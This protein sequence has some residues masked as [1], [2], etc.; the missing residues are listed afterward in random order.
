MSRHALARCLALCLLAL[1]APVA[2]QAQPAA[3][4]NESPPALTTRGPDAAELELQRALQGRAIEGRVTIPDRS[5]GVLVQP[6]GRD[7]R[8]YRNHWITWWGGIAVLGMLAVLLIVHL[9]KGTTRIAS[10]RTGRSIRRYNLLERANHWMVAVSFIGLALTGLNIIY[11]V[12]LLRPLIGPGAFATSAWWS[13]A[14]HQFVSFPF[15]IG[16]LLMLALWLR[17]NLPAR[18]D[19]AWL[20][21]GGPLSKGH[22]PAGRFNA[23]QKLLFWFVILAGLALAVSGY[24]LMF[25]L[26]VTDVHGQQWAHLVHGALSMLVI[27]AIL[28]HIYIGTIGTEGAFGAMYT[29]RVDWNYAREHHS[30]WLEE[31]VSRAQRAAEPQPATAR[32]AGAD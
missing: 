7:W 3:P 13:Q 5:L 18:V 22:P 30:L 21:A 26:T 9:W 6:Q 14:I 19:A 24:L 32:R 1:A 25:P 17:D 27:A 16:L 4:G 23:A 29:G 28:G 10:G 31:E 11:G 20:R 2:V 8:N 12:Y 15:V